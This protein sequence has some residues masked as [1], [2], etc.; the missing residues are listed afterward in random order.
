MGSEI[1]NAFTELNDP[2]EQRARFEEQER[3]R[4][5]F[6]DDEADRLDEDFLVAVEHGMP[7]MGGVGLGVDRLS[8]LIA[9]E[10]T[11]REVVLFPQM[12]N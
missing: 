12:R 3:M 6:G 1:C 8:M 9:G 7:P 5:E 2:A 10:E 4:L 11:I